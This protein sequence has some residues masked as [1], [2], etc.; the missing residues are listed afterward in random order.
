M[1][2]AIVSVGRIIHSENPMGGGVGGILLDSSVILD[3]T[4]NDDETATLRTGADYL[5]RKLRH[6]NIPTGISYAV[7]LSEAK[8]SLLEKLICVY[9]FEHFIY[10][11]SS[12]DDTVNAVSLAWDNN[13]AIILHVVSKYNEGLVP[14]SFSS[15][16]MNVFVNV[17]GDDASRNPTG[18]FIEKLE[19]LP[20]TV[21]ELNRKSSEGNLVV[22]YIMKPSRE[23]DFAKRG[24]FPLNPTQ[25]GLIFLP[26]TFDLP[27]LTQLKKV[28]I[29]IHKATDE[30]SSIERSN[31]SD[32]SSKIIYTR[33]MLELQRCIGELSDCCVIDPFDNI[34]PIVDRLK[35]QEILLGLEDLKTESQCKIRGPYYLKVDSFDDL[36][37][38][39]RLCGAKLSLPS[40]VK[41]QVACGAI[42][43]KAAD[44][45][46]LSVPLPAVVQEYVDHSSTLFKF[47]VLGE[48]I[49]EGTRDHVIV[50]VNYL[51]SFKE[52]PDEIAIP[53]FWD[54][55]K[56]KYLSKKGKNG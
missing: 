49:Q 16:W 56:M 10:N 54:A 19:E 43:F 32:C 35:I 45:T 30:I 3:S 1:D 17:D 51:P 27:I 40:I 24:A 47:Y 39:Q 34:F 55:I 53:A 13:G 46:G 14:K 2:M 28:E 15:G 50:D 48:K 37:L 25:N 5:L 41:P 22:G 29:V 36:E 52:V 38:E 4:S 31:S 8:V 18:I 42:V 7:G 33:G 26:L 11:P 23:E 21:C 9:S 44:F 20:L 12:L 6:S